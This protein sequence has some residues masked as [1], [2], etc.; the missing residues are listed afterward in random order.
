MAID[1]TRLYSEAGYSADDPEARAS[2]AVSEVALSVDDPVARASRTVSEVALSAD[3]PTARASR[4]FVE[5]AYAKPVEARASR[6]LVEVASYTVTADQILSA[7]LTE[8]NQ[9][10]AQSIYGLSETGVRELYAEAIGQWSTV[11]YP[12]PIYPGD[13]PIWWP[14]PVGGGGSGGGSGSGGGGSGGGGSVLPPGALY[15]DLWRVTVE[16][17]GDNNFRDNV[18]VVF[19]IL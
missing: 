6:L 2:R 12:P 11:R 5:V 13:P 10:G 8:Q 4:A 18:P 3:D 15:A 19:L 14:P 9:F 7:T 17:L 1:V 16:V